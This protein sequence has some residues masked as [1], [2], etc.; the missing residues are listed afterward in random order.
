MIEKIKS[1]KIKFTQPIAN[2]YLVLIDNPSVICGTLVVSMIDKRIL[3]ID[4][5]RYYVHSLKK[6]LMNE[7]LKE[8]GSDTVYIYARVDGRYLNYYAQLGFQT[9]NESTCDTDYVIMKYEM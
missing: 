9:C 6:S 7:F 4:F 8:I 1:A 5:N 3:D 2:V